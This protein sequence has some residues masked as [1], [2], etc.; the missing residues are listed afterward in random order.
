MA[1]DHAPT[2]ANKQLRAVPRCNQEILS[3][4]GGTRV[5]VIRAN[6]LACVAFA[7]A[8]MNDGGGHEHH[9]S[10]ELRN[11]DQPEW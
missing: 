2:N 10:A 1:E 8:T 5:M 6:G 9:I 3:S 4:H 7:N 11:A